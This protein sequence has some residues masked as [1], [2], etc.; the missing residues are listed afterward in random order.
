MFDDENFI[1]SAMGDRLI[2]SDREENDEEI[3]NTLR[4][5]GPQGRAGAACSGSAG[6]DS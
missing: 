2:G 5:K 1:T 4:Q 3:E 6:I